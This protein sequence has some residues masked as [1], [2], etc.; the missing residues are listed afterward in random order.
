MCYSC[1][2]IKM[3]NM[4][5]QVLILSIVILAACGQGENSNKVIES[6]IEVKAVSENQNKVDNALIF[7]N[8]YVENSSKMNNALGAIDWVNSN[9]LTTSRFKVE[10]KR[11]IDDALKQDPELGLGTDPILDAQDNPSE[12]FELESFDD[13]TNYLI[14]KGKDWPKF[15]LTMKVVEEKGNWL[16]DGC[17]MVN[18]PKDIRAER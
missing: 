11:I 13:K 9:S 10:L 8:G 3:K 1:A 7:I 5:R 17:G 2:A 6:K 15:K 18:I 4:L 12:G 16:V 14:V